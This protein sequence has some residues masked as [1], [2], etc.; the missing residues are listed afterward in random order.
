MS[1]TV[2]TGLSMARL[3]M[4]SE[5]HY[6]YKLVWALSIG[7]KVLSTLYI[8]RFDSKDNIYYIIFLLIKSSE[9]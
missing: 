3:T 8:L 5:T 9:N 4:T 6:S 7:G 2:H 1:S